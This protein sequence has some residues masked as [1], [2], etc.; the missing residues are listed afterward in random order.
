MA[1]TAMEA[2]PLRIKLTKAVSQ[3]KDA[4]LQRLLLDGNSSRRNDENDLRTLLGKAVS[5]GYENGA[6]LLLEAG[7]KID[8]VGSHG[9][10]HGAIANTNDKTRN[11]IITLLLS[12]GCEL[13]AKDHLGRT[14][15]MAACLRG[16][17][18]VIITLLTRGADPNVE[19]QSG[20]NALQLMASESKRNTKWSPEALSMLLPKVRDLNKRDSE[21]R[22]GRTP[23]LWAAARGQLA[24]VGALL[25]IGKGVVDVNQTNDQGHSALH[26]AARH[27]E[28][29]MIK[30][31]I[32]SGAKIEAR[33]DGDWTP[34]LMAAKEGN[35]SA[36]DAL[37][38]SNA[39]V[40][41]RTSSGMTSL[42][43]AAESG[44][45]DAVNRIMRERHAHKNSKDS[46]DSTP[47]IRA[48]QNGH[49]D[50][51]DALRPYVLEG[52]T[53]S[54]ARK[55]C[56]RFRAAVVNFFED[57]DAHGGIKNKVNKQTVWQIL[58]ARDEK[59]PDMPAIP[60]ALD[61]VEGVKKPL[62]R[63]I[64]LPANNIS[65]LEALLTKYYL[66]GECKDVTVLKSL[67]RLL[68][69]Q[70]HR[71]SEI[72]SRFMRPSCKRIWIPPKRSVAD[73]AQ[74][75]PHRPS[76]VGR[77]V[78][79][80]T[81]P[82]PSSR[83][84]APATAAQTQPQLEED[85]MVM[86]M[87]YLHWETDR[88]RTLLTQSIREP[89][90]NTHALEESELS[91]IPKD[92]L[93][94]HGY[95]GGS[96][97]LHPRRTLDQF[98]HHSTKTDLQDAD[99]VV[100]R[101]C[102]RSR[103]ELKIFMVDQLW[104]ISIG[105]LLISCF[106]ERW[107]QPHR[108]PL[109]LFEGVVEDIN[110][111]TRPPV[112]NVFELATVITERC[113]GLFDRQ[114]WDSDDL[115]FAEM[116]ELSIGR[117]T[118]KETKLFQRFKEASSHWLRAHD[119]GKMLY[120]SQLGLLEHDHDHEQSSSGW[121][122]SEEERSH[123]HHHGGGG[124]SSH[125][126]QHQGRLLR[127]EDSWHDRHQASDSFVN[128]LLNIDNEAAL[129]VECKDVEDELDILTSVL[130]QQR[131]VLNDFDATLRAA[132]NIVRTHRLDLYGK[133]SEQ[134]R[135]VDL[136]VLD[137][138]RMARQAKSVNDNLTQ[139][140]DLKQKHANA[141]EARFQRKQAEETARQGQTIMVFTIVTIVF[142]PLSFLASFFAIDVI[143][144][145]RPPGTAAQGE[146]HLSWVVQYILGI[147]LAVSVPLIGLAFVVGDIQA[148]WV[149]RKLRKYHRRRRNGNGNGNGN[150]NDKDNRKKSHRVVGGVEDDVR[151]TDDVD[152]NDKKRTSGMSM[153]LMS[154]A[155][156]FGFGFG[157][158]GLRRRGGRPAWLVMGRDREK[159]QPPGLPVS[160][161]NLFSSLPQGRS[162]GSKQ[163]DDEKPHHPR[164]ANGNN[165]QMQ[166][167]TQSLVAMSIQ[168]SGAQ[169]GR[170]PMSSMES[171]RQGGG[172][173]RY[174]RRLRRVGTETTERSAATEDLEV[175]GGFG[176]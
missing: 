73:P 147:G 87:P 132:K 2:R 53:N 168:A 7:A 158:G 39:N 66:E 41:V 62:F 32:F 35:E 94:I 137:L 77:K 70:Q 37:L 112:R 38:T 135:L 92:I 80:S 14:G 30:L 51:V 8:G 28:P 109:N 50:I 100:Y 124:V 16:Q 27:N 160:N 170:Q 126:T 130:R 122:S 26:L 69:R 91:K 106:P 46:F 49:W 165:N 65:W 145:P 108:D 63:W 60:I 76:H 84:T 111:T 115:L 133:V 31:L 81:P 1:A 71:G 102:R 152:N 56:Q 67:L 96:T 171:S 19:D 68:G 79:P 150:G 164:R 90:G 151:F 139:V 148:W 114:Q 163:R 162:D 155:P 5:I 3:K 12:H 167:Q 103:K 105:N 176:V 74:S 13:E 57:K 172:G 156:G 107:R 82:P 89:S 72:H 75:T 34:L 149:N 98:K 47:L 129:L 174:P 61:H 125:T 140:L 58:Y 99:Q 20:K 48:A 43:W 97:D 110:S 119:G 17:N 22:E 138:G 24:L 154:W 121:S 85:M 136:D 29:E 169:G 11:A 173:A 141:V 134:Q 127:T 45:L 42:H 144:F 88:N 120:K 36:I 116:F 142:L 33:S 86:F 4:D 83:S 157:G 153:G 159:R 44:K 131:Q 54:V 93:L 161:A 40:N 118:R 23:L 10:L 104:L 25:Q 175:G 101:Y 55:A 52:P 18:D 9:P 146:L 113:T 128:D 21:G 117:L 64:H 78:T 6:R 59:A 166:T 143:E 123:H 95:V 15:L